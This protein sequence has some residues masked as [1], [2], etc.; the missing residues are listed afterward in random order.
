MGSFGDWQR[1]G[2][3]NGSRAT[4]SNG[5]CIRPMPHGCTLSLA[6]SLKVTVRNRQSWLIAGIT[7]AEEGS[8]PGAPAGSWPGKLSPS[9]G[10]ALADLS[11]RPRKRSPAHGRL[12][13]HST[14]LQGNTELQVAMLHSDRDPVGRGELI[15]RLD[16]RHSPQY[17]AQQHL[18]DGWQRLVVHGR[19]AGIES[20]VL[21]VEPAHS[22][23]ERAGAPSSGRTGR[24]SGKLAP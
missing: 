8:L 19:A 9:V 22:L 4:F 13:D 3:A 5:P 21:P 11:F 1:F 7:G 18:R 15:D 16:G 20:F 17:R 12:R 10:P 14:C 2:A 23:E 24:S 6:K